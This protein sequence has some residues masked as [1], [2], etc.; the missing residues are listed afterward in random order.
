[1]ATDLS[2]LEDFLNKMVVRFNHPDFI[3]ADPISIPHQFQQLQ[4]IEIMGFW[5]A[6]LSWGQRKTI[7][8]KAQELIQLMDG[9]PYQF[10]LNHQEEDRKRFENFKH[11]TFQYT[12]TLYFL[13]FLQTYYSQNN[14][15]ET[16]FLTPAGDFSSAKASITQFHETFFSLPDAPKRTK[17]HIA[18]PARKSTCKR[19]NMFLRWMVRQDNCGV[20]FGLWR[21]IPSSK[22][23]MPFD[24]HVERIGRQL[25]LIQ[26]KQRDW[27]AVEELTKQLSA[28]DEQDPVKYDYALFGLGV[29]EKTNPDFKF[30]ITPDQI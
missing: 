18:S 2:G 7:I 12:D 13:E 15:L 20:D 26:R 4:D 3:E 17:K 5:T 6:I 28:F 14:S 25:G 29:L 11:R 24:V 27:Q 30:P 22:L 10:I 21:C 1:M 19:L 8:N 16:A 23:M 9:A